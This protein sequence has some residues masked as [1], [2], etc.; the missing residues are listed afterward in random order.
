MKL[1]NSFP[2]NFFFS[3]ITIILWF[4]SILIVFYLSLIPQVETPIDFKYSDKVWHV[5][6]YLWLSFLPYVGFEYRKKA[7]LGSLL[8]IV[9]GVGLEFGQSFIPEREATISDLIAN[10]I[11]VV[12]GILFGS[13]LRRFYHGNFKR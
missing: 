11:G 9:L 5:L 1:K 4:F 7:L 12:T 13:T 8:M 3:K 2:Y 10:N 6:T